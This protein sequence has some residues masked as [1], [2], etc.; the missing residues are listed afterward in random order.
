VDFAGGKMK[1]SIAR[2]GPEQALTGILTH[3]GESGNGDATH[4]VIFLNAGLV[5]RIGPNRLY[6]H[7]ARALSAAGDL[8][9][10]FD[11]SGIGDSGVTADS[12]RPADRFVAEAGAA[13]DF[14]Q[15]RFGVTSFTL[16]GICSG[17]AVSYM[18]AT[19]DRRVSDIWLINPPAPILPERHLRTLRSHPNR[20]RKLLTMVSHRLRRSGSRPKRTQTSTVAD[21]PEG[22]TR[23]AE[24]GCE[25]FIVSSEWHSGYDYLLGV[26]PGRLGARG[27]DER[28][29]IAAVR[30]ADHLFHLIHHQDQLTELLLE[31][32]SR[33]RSKGVG[34]STE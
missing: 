23:L 4:A 25:V 27:V 15:E 6:V 8:V 22:I 29:S 3:P 21:I 5:H 28:V 16:T 7:L 30:G 33:R 32:A 9:L 10:R 11:H 17:A 14:L 20:W 26:L 12:R 24:E 18:A 1:E 2:F 19:N 31:R 13:M 34:V